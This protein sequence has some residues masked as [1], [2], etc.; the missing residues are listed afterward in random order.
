M[1]TKKQL[2]NLADIRQQEKSYLEHL[3]Q[4]AAILNQRV[5][6][7]QVKPTSAETPEEA[8]TLSMSYKGGIDLDYMADLL[9][10]TQDEVI[11]D[12][13][14]ETPTPLMYFDPT[15]DTWVHQSIFL[16]GNA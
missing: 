14:S 16:S 2:Q 11:K 6:F 12:L 13:H 1:S 9:G 8:L 4:K 15:T 10:V 3:N 7:K 5:I